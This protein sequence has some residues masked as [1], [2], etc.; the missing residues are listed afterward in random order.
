MWCIVICTLIDND[1]RHHRSCGLTRHSQASP[2]QILTTVMTLIVVGKRT[3]FDFFFTIISTSKEMCV[4]HSSKQRC[5]DSC[6]Q[7]HITQTDCEISCN[8]G[9]RQRNKQTKQFVR[10]FFSSIATGTRC[11]MRLDD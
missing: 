2:Q 1:M 10:F 7:R 3:R 11:I 4:T 5:L 8:C 6:R 9:K